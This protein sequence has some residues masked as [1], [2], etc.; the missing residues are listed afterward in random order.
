MLQ[1]TCVWAA[2]GGTEGVAPRE[3]PV[4]STMVRLGLH[5]MVDSEGFHIW[6]CPFG[7]LGSLVASCASLV[8]LPRYLKTWT[9][10]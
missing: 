10:G 2:H 9:W 6:L 8:S 7:G 3:E 4:L 1:G 5:I